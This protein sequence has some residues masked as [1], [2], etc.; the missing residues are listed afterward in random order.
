MYKQASEIIWMRLW[1][2]QI[3]NKSCFIY[4]IFCQRQK[5]ELAHLLDRKQSSSLSNINNDE[6]NSNNHHMIDRLFCA[7]HSI[8]GFALTVSFNSVNSH[9][10]AKT[11]IISVS[12]MRKQRP[13]KVTYLVLSHMEENQNLDSGLPR[14]LFLF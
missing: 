12:Q 3:L 6:N 13:R 8:R 9:T 2:T 5:A 11:I 14:V 4:L 7:S 10:I 1:I